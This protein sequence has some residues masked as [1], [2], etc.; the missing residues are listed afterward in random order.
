M[1]RGAALGGEHVEKQGELGVAPIARRSFG[2][3]Q[4]SALSL[5]RPTGIERLEA[6]T[7]GFGI[8]PDPLQGAQRIAEGDDVGALGAVPTKHGGGDQHDTPDLA[9]IGG[10]FQ[11]GSAPVGGRSPS[12]GCGV[13]LA[14]SNSGIGTS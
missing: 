14:S 10:L 8:E 4:G 13:L 6:E 1:G 7:A 5:R 9:G 2:G 11:A 3:G 12:L